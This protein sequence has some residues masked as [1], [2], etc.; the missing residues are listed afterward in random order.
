[1]R[2]TAG[3]AVVVA[4]GLLAG[5]VGV[6]AIARA[7]PAA[8]GTAF[9]ATV[10]RRSVLVQWSG[11]KAPRGMKVR[12]LVV[13]RDG[14]AVARLSTRAL[15]FNDERVNV[16]ETHEYA[17][18]L[19][20]TQRRRT[21]EWLA[22]RV[23]AQLP[24]Y[25]VGAANRDITPVGTI[26]LGGFGLGDGRLFPQEVV[27]R[28]DV[29]SAK[30]ER[31]RSRAV[32]FDDGRGGAIA[33]ASIETQGMFAAY[34]DGSYGLLDMAAR[35][36]RRVPGLPA[37]H[38]VIAADHTHS[39]PDTIGAWGG[40]PPAYIQAIADRTVD[41]IEEAYRTRAF[42]DVRV[43][44]S[45]AADLIY[46]QSCSEALNQEKTPTYPGPDLCLTP[47]KD[48]LVRVVQARNPTAGTIVTLMAYAAHST[49]GGGDGIHGDWPQFM[50]DAMAA[51]YGG[52]GQAMV[53]AI[54]G[55]QPC[56]SA[57]AF[58]ERSNP[59]YLIPD[60]KSAIVHNYL[61]HVDDALNRSR[62]VS[63]PVSGAQSYFREPIV[64]APVLALFTGGSLAGAKL[65]R[66]H[67]PPWTVAT[68]IRSVA[69]VVRV[70]GVVFAGFP[71]EAYHAMG[72]GMRLAIDGEDEVIPLG[73][74]NDQLGYLI[75]PAS[76]FPVIAAEVAVNDNILFNVSP[77]I[78]DHVM[79]TDIALAARVGLPVT[80]PAKCLGYNA[81]DNSGDPLA[82][83]P[84][85][86]P[87]L[88]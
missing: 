25:L 85:G 82:A 29:G 16:Q 22:F 73:L 72:E 88:P 32:V 44:S 6:P 26:N 23:Q 3:R 42:A 59:G 12:S 62:P 83:I 56:R 1:M 13:R 28:G 43:G 55:V 14:V 2:V 87:T 70:G 18:S 15:S 5:V 52:F 67:T 60:R 38:I 47:G 64:G 20:G 86:A 81:L 79:C 65:L 58:T 84:V 45:N 63:G 74:A 11:L 54:G 39:G 48:G 75:S 46:N 76:Y 19:S 68:T 57:C 8:A 17:L 4:V 53:G 50:S 27:G 61:A 31:I 35:V 7:V 36:A 9:S 40:V 69:S 66:A 80:S 49:A 30:K 78:G 33:I 41:A 77:T 24:S 71:G 51:R 34:E 37:D 10:Q 21:I